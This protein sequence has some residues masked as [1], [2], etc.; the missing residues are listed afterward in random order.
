VQKLQLQV[1]M[2]QQL[3]ILVM[4]LAMLVMMSSTLNSQKPSNSNLGF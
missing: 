4:D 2:V 1:T 3:V